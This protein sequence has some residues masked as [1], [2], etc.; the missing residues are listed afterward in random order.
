MAAM[1]LCSASQPNRKIKATAS[2]GAAAS[3]SNERGCETSAPA[4]NACQHHDDEEADDLGTG[5]SSAS[6]DATWP[7]RGPWPGRTPGSAT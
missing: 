3:I 1:S 6:S 5:S 7:L 2:A 4:Q